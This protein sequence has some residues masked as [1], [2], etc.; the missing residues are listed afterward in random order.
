MADGVLSFPFR[1]DKQGHV[2]T[3]ERGSDAEVEEALA[4]LVMTVTGERL[5]TPEFGVP[6]PTFVGLT[7]SD[8][9]AGV[10]DWG[11]S[12]ISI[13]SVTSQ[14]ENET[15]ARTTISWA[16]DQVESEDDGE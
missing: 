5:M 13:V 8:V 15:T 7:L 1:L 4:V 16:R 11:P 3:T 9:A 2:A 14:P 6:D 12:G 10:S